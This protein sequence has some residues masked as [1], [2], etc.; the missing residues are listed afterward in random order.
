MALL[1]GKAFWAKV[2]GE[3]KPGYD[4]SKREWSID[5]AIDDTTRKALAKE[6]LGSYIKNKGDERGDFVSFKRKELKSD[7]TKAK[8]IRIVDHNG[9][10]WPAKK[11]I[12]NGSTVNVKYLINEYEYNGKKGKKPGILAI[13]VWDLV[14]YEGKDGDQEDFPTRDG[15]ESWS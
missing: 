2:V 5:V 12:G 7:G 1:Q 13:Q 6:G 11:L 8:P 4:K 9:Q 3:P 10:D 14:E 15:E